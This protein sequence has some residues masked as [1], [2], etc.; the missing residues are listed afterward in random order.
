M[1]L[2]EKRI[3]DA[4]PGLKTAIL[5]DDT[6]KNFGLR[7]TPRGAKSYVV[8]YFDAS[9]KRHRMTL[10]RASEISLAEARQ[11]AGKELAAVRAGEADLLQRRETARVAPTFADLWDRFETEFAPERVALGRLRE[12]TLATYRKQARLYLLPTFADR[13]V[14]DLTRADVDRMARR[15]AHAPAQRNRTLALLSRLCTLAEAWEWRPQASNPVKGVMRAREEARD[16]TLSG[17]ELAALGRALDDLA[18]TYPAAVAAIRVAA[19]SGMRIGEVIGMKWPNVDFERG[20]VTLLATKTGRQVRVLPSA[21]LDLLAGMPRIHDCDAVFT[22]TGRTPI[23]YR[24]VRVVFA[25]ACALAGLDGVRLHDLRR[26]VATNAAAAGIGV[27]LLRDILGH[28]T[29]TMSARYVRRAGGALNDAVE[30]SG[31]AMAA[32]M[33]GKGGEVVPMERRHG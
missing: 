29:I 6:V 10:A 3:R 1:N 24:Y 17:A 12:T 27:T 19:L 11:R 33:A 21:V 31:A 32:A 16:R 15:M 8:D 4:R 18:D 9:G 22:A 28:S 23:R 20:S 30:N 13:R 2:T 26:T 14:A 7:V 25:K 5:W